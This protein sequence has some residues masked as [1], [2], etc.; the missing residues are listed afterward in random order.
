MLGV[1]SAALGAFTFALNNAGKSAAAVR[2][3][4]ARRWN[5]TIAI[6]DGAP[7]AIGEVAADMD[8]RVWFLD[9]FGHGDHRVEMDEL[10]IVFGLG[11]RPDFRSTH[12][13][14]AAYEPMSS[15][16][17]DNSTI[18]QPSPRSRTILCQA[19][20]KASTRTG[21]S[22]AR[23]SVYRHTRNAVEL[24][25]PA[26]SGAGL[27]AALIVIAVIGALLVTVGAIETYIC[28][29]AWIPG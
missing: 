22:I 11:F 5:P 3:I 6:A 26:R 8:R 18:S 7:R 2:D 15:L 27:G 24:G 13:K 12:R 14:S 21:R 29:K 10:P 9:R 25:A 20:G 19:K 1:L 28:R 16:P 23:E 4:A 17:S